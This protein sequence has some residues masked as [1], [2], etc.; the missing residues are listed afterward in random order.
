MSE[1][2]SFRPRGVI[3][4]VGA[5]GEVSPSRE[6]IRYL[7]LLRRRADQSLT[8]ATA[9][10]A[11]TRYAVQS[12]AVAAGTAYAAGTPGARAATLYEADSAAQAGTAYAPEAVEAATTEYV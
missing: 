12:D 11:G 7:D 6:L 10:P 4:T 9:G 3:G 1:L 5:R 2:P 8:P